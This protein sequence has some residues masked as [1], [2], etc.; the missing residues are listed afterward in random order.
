[1]SVEADVD[2]VRAVQAVLDDKPSVVYLVNKKDD[3]KTAFCTMAQAQDFVRIKI[4][5]ALEDALA[6]VRKNFDAE[7]TSFNAQPNYWQ[8]I[9][10]EEVLVS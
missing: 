6:R 4:N 3:W 8:G 5:E 7:L 10:I 2:R 9:F 1:M